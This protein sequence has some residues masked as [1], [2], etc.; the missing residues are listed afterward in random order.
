MPKSL[1]ILLVEDDRDDIELFE[2]ALRENNVQWGLTTL[3]QG[4]KVIPWLK[5][6]QEYPDA[7]VL[8]LN[9]P[10]IHGREILLKIRENEAY[11]DIEVVILSTS[12]SK[13]EKDFCLKN[14]AGT[15]ITKPTTLEGFKETVAIIEK[16]LNKLKSHS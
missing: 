5:K 4:D 7:I 9:I 2:N 6:C 11:A 1:H 14:G 8:D 13:V 16:V 10:K 3:M 15:F 12:A